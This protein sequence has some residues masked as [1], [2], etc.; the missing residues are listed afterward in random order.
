MRPRFGAFSRYRPRVL[1]LV[2][3]FAVAAP[4][5]LAN[6]SPTD[7]T[8]FGYGGMANVEYGWPLIWYL[9]NFALKPGDT[10]A[11]WHVMGY[12]WLRLAGNL[13]IWSVML[14]VAGTTCEWLLRRYRPRLRWSLRTMLI[15]VAILAVFCAWCAMLRDRAIVQDTFI[16]EIDPHAVAFGGPIYLQRWG[17]KWL[18]LVGV[19]R[20]RRRIA[21]VNLNGA[22]EELLKRV[23]RMPGLRILDLSNFEWTSGVAAA[24]GEMRQLRSLVIRGI[25]SPDDNDDN[26][27]ISDEV[28]TAVGK[29]KQLRELRLSEMMIT[30]DSLRHLAE[31]TDL[32]SLHLDIPWVGE[33]DQDDEAGPELE[34]K[35]EQ[36]AYAGKIPL[37]AHLPALPR[38]EAIEFH[39][40]L[41]RLDDLRRFASLPRLKALDLS[42]SV[43]SDAALA[44]LA[45][46]ESL[47][48][49]A[50]DE[51]F[52]SEA[53]LESL[54]PLKRLKVLH[55]IDYRD[56]DES[57]VPLPLDHDGQVFV[58]VS[59][60]DRCRK[61]L[62]TLRHSNPGIVVDDVDDPIFIDELRHKRYDFGPADRRW[63]NGPF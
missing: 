7:F 14:V 9:R 42:Y 13:A 59:E 3:L 47:E 19:D 28:L 20:Y 48:E 12:H 31:L 45:S 8:P 34:H 39:G 23:G 41:V 22:D 46:L 52:A 49:L 54:L 58:R 32:K 33:D 43:V 40:G 15:A 6:F 44:E 4:T 53:G 56:T 10:Q 35:L 61:A 50:V 37:L 38:L 21:G 5:V 29:L 26:E 25:Y 63:P 16:A 27:R 36:F 60:V 57:Q 11:Q 55:L 18:D 1:T 51:H 17:P 62:E 30:S 2:V 24:L